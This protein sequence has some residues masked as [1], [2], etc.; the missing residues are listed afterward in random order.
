MT[1]AYD[2]ALTFDQC[3]R[4]AAED[5]VLFFDAYPQ[6]GKAY[7]EMLYAPTTRPETARF[8]FLVLTAG[9]KEQF[10]RYLE[11]RVVKEG[12]DPTRFEH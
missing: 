7:T 10:E 5:Q 2:V 6:S 4:A 3:L 1:Y 12:P 8:W 9:F 11:T